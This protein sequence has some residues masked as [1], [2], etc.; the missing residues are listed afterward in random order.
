[1]ETSTKTLCVLRPQIQ[2]I[3]QYTT[4][5]L[6]ERIQLLEGRVERLEKYTN[7]VDHLLSSIMIRSIQFSICAPLLYTLWKGL[8]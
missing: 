2:Q 3:V 6:L 4:H 7:R 8:R 5:P 1:M